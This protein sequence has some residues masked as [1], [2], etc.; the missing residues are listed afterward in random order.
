MERSQ[1]IMSSSDEVASLLPEALKAS[2]IS[3]RK[4]PT[5]PGVAMQ[6]ISL[7]SHPDI[8]PVDLAEVIEADPGLATRIMQ[9]A[10]SPLYANRRQVRHL[11]DALTYLGLDAAINIS[12]GFSL[13]QNLKSQADGGSV[14]EF[15]I[16]A[17]MAAVAAR[18]LALFKAPI[19]AEE[20]LLAGLL[21][22]IG[23]LGLL[24]ACEPE[25]SQLIE[26]ATSHQQLLEL[27]KQHF[28]ITHGVVGA[29]LLGRWRLRPALA[30]STLHAD[31]YLPLPNGDILPEGPLLAAI[32]G[33]AG[34]IADYF[35]LSSESEDLRQPLFALCAQL[36]MDENGFMRFLDAVHNRMERLSPI[37]DVEWP[38][39][40]EREELLEE[41]RD[42]IFVRQLRSISFAV[43]AARHAEDTVASQATLE[44]Q[45]RRDALTGLFNRHYLDQA[46]AKAF[47]AAS[48]QGAMPLSLIFLDL[49]HFKRVNDRYGHQTGD[50]VLRQFGQILLGQCRENDIAARYGGEEFVILLPNTPIE[51]AVNVAERLRSQLAAATY[52]GPQGERLTVTLSAGVAAHPTP[53]TFGDLHEHL[54][55]ADRAL[56]AAKL[57]GRNRIVVYEV[58]ED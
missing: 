14:G 52:T 18:E 33:R 10:N 32:A 43:K 26:Q 55:A 48:A 41:S 44:E 31:E 6:I 7:A 54:R 15:W 28:G 2:L 35:S 42:L 9:I 38:T 4:L 34:L 22:D 29:W 17:A 37:F 40:I 50:E 58:P 19:Y 23:V 25:Y 16:R 45:A 12:L 46:L 30:E 13:L 21:Q 51:D 11:R 24:A 36:G 53:A 3:C 8:R 27:E 57:A 1:R 47:K 20:A 49:D 39:A 5:P 56:Y